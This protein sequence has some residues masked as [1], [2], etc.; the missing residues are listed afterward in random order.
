MFAQS[1]ID[2]RGS[3]SNK[4]KLCNCHVCF[5][6]L[7]VFKSFFLSLN[8]QI[9]FVKDQQEDVTAKLH[10]E[11]LA[12]EEEIIGLGL[13]A[14]FSL[15]VLQYTSLYVSPLCYSFHLSLR[16]ARFSVPQKQMSKHFIIYSTVQ[17]WLCTP[18]QWT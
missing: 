12:L 5:P 16:H 9:N 10:A 11:Y 2:T 6:S 18:P 17:F 1:V 3:L 14:S 4:V 13:E 7:Y 8:H 15:L